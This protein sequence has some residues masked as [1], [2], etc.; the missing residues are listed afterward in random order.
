MRHA[1]N[2]INPTEAEN[3]AALAI[4]LEAIK[5]MRAE[6]EAQRK[7]SLIAIGA[8]S[9]S[10]VWGQHGVCNAGD[11]HGPYMVLDIAEHT[12]GTMSY[13]TVGE[14]HDALFDGPC[15]LEIIMH[16]MCLIHLATDVEKH[17]DYP[18]NVGQ[19]E[20][21]LTMIGTYLVAAVPVIASRRE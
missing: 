11:D 8:D 7:L 19:R 14:L 1:M 6:P 16:L 10:V 15:A 17:G 20:R 2:P 21:E 5:G 9:K 4:V 18:R 13:I 12:N 3:T